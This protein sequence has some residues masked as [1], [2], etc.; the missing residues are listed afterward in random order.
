MIDE[1]NIKKIKEV[2][3][4]FLHK[5]TMPPIKLDITC[6]PGDFWA[7]SNTGDVK[8]SEIINIQIILQEPQFLIGQ[9]GQTLFELE[10]ILKI[11]LN[12]K[13]QEK[14]Y[15]NIDIND[16]KSKKIE[17]LKNLAQDLAGGVVLTR[18]KKILLPMSAYERRIIHKELD[19]RHDIITQSHGEGEERHIVISPA[20]SF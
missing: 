7:G 11:V 17:Y 12:K 20:D 1:S 10:R 9:N 8:N 6:S 13:L 2:V 15:V 3:E 18:E 19:Q 14:F 5:M 16:Y 4:E